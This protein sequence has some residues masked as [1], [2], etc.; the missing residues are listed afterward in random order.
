[1]SD[2]VANRFAGNIVLLGI[3][4]LFIAMAFGLANIV[5]GGSTFRLLVKVFGFLWLPLIGI[6]AVMRVANQVD[7]A[8][9]QESA[10]DSAD[11]N[12]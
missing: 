4:C 9:S 10:D 1:V 12:T 8:Q 11:S 3:V 2:N 6:G 5:Y 7:P